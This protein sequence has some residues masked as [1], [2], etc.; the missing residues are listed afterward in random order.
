M[1]TYPDSHPSFQRPFPDD[2]ACA[3]WLIE[4]R[5]P[6]GLVCPNCSHDKGW[7]LR[8]KPHAFECA[9]SGRQTSVTAGTVLHAGALPL[10]IRY[11]SA[12]LLAHT[13]GSATVDPKRNPLSGLVVVDEVSLSFRSRNDP[14]ASGQDRSHDGKMLMIGALEPG[15]GNTPDRLRLAE[16][17][18]YGAD[19]IGGLFLETAASSD[20]TIKTDGWHGYAVVP[21]DPHE[22]HVV[23]GTPT[24]LVFPWIRQIYSNVKGR[25][26]GVYHG[27]RHKHLQ[28]C[29]N[30]FV[31][32]FNR[33]GI[34]HAAFHSLFTL[35]IKAQPMIYNMLI[36]PEPCAQVV[37]TLRP[38]AFTHNMLAYRHRQPQF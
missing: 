15:D 12:W 6:D 21:S 1:P 33:H 2:D 29:L 24:V 13:L 3:A 27:L 16:I 26:R 32:R 23:G 25:A 31:L 35:A 4:M 17:A 9:G 5:W 20:A 14:P 18:S 10:T 7:A 30:E 8:G 28:A 38:H 37:S 11:R 22:V 34:R 36:K 19:D